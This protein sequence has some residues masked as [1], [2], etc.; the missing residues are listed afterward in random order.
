MAL[1]NSYNKVNACRKPAKNEQKKANKNRICNENGEAN[2]VKGGPQELRILREHCPYYFEHLF[3]VFNL[4]NSSLRVLPVKTSTLYS[5]I[6]SVGEIGGKLE[7]AAGHSSGTV[8][9]LCSRLRWDIGVFVL[10]L[11][12]C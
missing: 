10:L 7:P 6:C 9:N 8:H 3:E 4:V 12:A 2:R 1:F 11:R 5:D